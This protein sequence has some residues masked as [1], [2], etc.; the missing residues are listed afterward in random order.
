MDN[1]L[2]M[3]RSKIVQREILC[4]IRD[5]VIKILVAEH[6]HRIVGIGT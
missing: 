2:K 1:T 5:W 6:N 3:N 4:Q